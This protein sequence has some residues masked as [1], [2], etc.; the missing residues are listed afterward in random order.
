[1][2][3]AFVFSGDLGRRGIP[4]IRDPQTVDGA[5]FLIMES[6]YG[7]RLHPPYEDDTKQMERII[8]ETY[9]RAVIGR[10][11][12]VR[13]RTQQLIYTL[14][15]LTV[16]GDIPQIPVF[17]DSPLAIDVTSVFRLHPE[18]YDA[19]TRA[20]MLQVQNGRSADVFGFDMLHYTRSVELSKQLN[21]MRDPAIIISASGMA[22]TGRILHH[23]KKQSR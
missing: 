17:I 23:L 6:T 14:H 22:E 10:H 7:D 1:M 19:E 11:S 21:Y 18:C 13:T 2:R 20:F 16:K 5:D 9:K 3:F 12:V 8:T 15:Q 4:I